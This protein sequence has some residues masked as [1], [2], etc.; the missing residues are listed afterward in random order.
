MSLCTLW[1]FQQKAS[2]TTKMS[3]DPANRKFRPTVLGTLLGTQK[4]RGEIPIHSLGEGYVLS[5]ARSH[6]PDFGDLRLRVDDISKPT[7][8]LIGAYLAVRGY[9]PLITSF[10][11]PGSINTETKS[12]TEVLQPQ[13]VLQP[14]ERLISGLVRH[15][16]PE[17]CLGQW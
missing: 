13:G 3:V 15:P 7:E 2:A 6:L 4:D 12:W 8:R 16:G 10:N 11:P 14:Q 5:R 17:R 1:K 9:L